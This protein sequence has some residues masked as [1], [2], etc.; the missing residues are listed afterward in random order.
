MGGI[1]QQLTA[2][3]LVISKVYR[4]VVVAGVVLVPDIPA[5]RHSEQCVD[6]GWVVPLTG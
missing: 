3:L 4:P 5:R 6:S 1:K 2:N